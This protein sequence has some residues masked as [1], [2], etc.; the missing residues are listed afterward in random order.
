MKAGYRK[1]SKFFRALGIAFQNPAALNLLLDQEDLHQQA[2]QKFQGFEQGLPEVS[3]FSLVEAPIVVA[4]FAFLDGG[5]LPT[6]LALLRALGSRN[7]NSYFEI[8]TWRGESVR[9][10]ADIVPECTSLHLG[11]EGMRKRGWSEE[12]ILQHEYFSSGHQNIKHVYG[13]SREFDFSAFEQKQDLVFVDGDHHFD[14]VVSDTRAAFRLLKDEHSMIVWHDYGTSP[15]HV[16]W[17]VLHGILKGTPPEKRSN[18]Y[19]VSNTLCAVYLPEKL[20][21]R[22]RSYPAIPENYFSIEIHKQGG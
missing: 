4:P 14:S 20:H 7:C 15:E 8:G 2:V 22:Q 10:V 12:Y 5:S 9:N 3:F 11:A 1:L 6:D 19:A 13:D 17:S 16:R 21:T 18:L